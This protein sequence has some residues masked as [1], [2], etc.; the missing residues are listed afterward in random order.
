[1]STT[2]SVP[3]TYALTVRLEPEAHSLL[4]AWAARGRQGQFLSRL[5]FEE[6]IRREERA[7]A[8]LT[9]LAGASE[10]PGSLTP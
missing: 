8:A 1:M 3:K 4:R 9:E 7:R 10:T 6:R 2:A 5:L